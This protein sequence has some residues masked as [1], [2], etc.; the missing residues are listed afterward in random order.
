ANRIASDTRRFMAQLPPG[1]VSCCRRGP[2][3]YCRDYPP[4]A[5][6]EQYPCPGHTGRGQS[7]HGPENA[8]H[9]PPCHRPPTA[10]HRGP[11]RR[12]VPPRPLRRVAS[13]TRVL[14][15]CKRDVMSQASLPGMAWWQQVLCLEALLLLDLDLG[16]LAGQ[17]TW[18]EG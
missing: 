9:A 11:R 17:V 6:G 2:A 16:A 18:L 7:G 4:S 3:S 15:S 12:P 10:R 13:P 1:G 14:C 5:G 8:T